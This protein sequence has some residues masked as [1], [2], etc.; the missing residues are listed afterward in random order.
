MFFFCA[1]CCIIVELQ[2]SIAQEKK[3]G[4][5]VPADSMYNLIIITNYNYSTEWKQLTEDVSMKVKGMHDLYALHTDIKVALKVWWSS[6]SSC[7]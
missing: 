1:I 4:V 3:G 5:L 2:K 6:P 7:V